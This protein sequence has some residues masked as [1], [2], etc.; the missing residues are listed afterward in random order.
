M[1]SKKIVK[2][3]CADAEIIPEYEFDNDTVHNNAIGFD[4]RSKNRF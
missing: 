3:H 4:F 2:Q 1:W